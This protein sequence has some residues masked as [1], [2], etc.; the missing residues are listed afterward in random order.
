MLSKKDFHQAANLFL[1]CKNYEQALDAY[2]NN[3]DWKEMLLI[4]KILKY[5]EAKIKNLELDMVE[6]LNTLGKYS[7]KLILY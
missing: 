6:Y 4:A 1:S 7:V 5:D 2:K 3:G